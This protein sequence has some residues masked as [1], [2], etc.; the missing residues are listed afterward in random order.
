VQAGAPLVWKVKIRE[1]GKFLVGVKSTTGI[2]QRKTVVIEPPND[3]AGRFN[4]EFAGD[5][6]PGKQFTITAKV[7]EPLPGQ[8]LTATLPQG[9]Q[10]ANGDL[11]QSVAPGKE[12][13][14]SW[15]V[16]VV[17]SGRLPVRIASSTGLARTKTISLTESNKTLFGN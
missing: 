4:F 9:L 17:E 7:T 15:Q 1:A 13:I 5:I 12:S 3:L 11:T 10:L 14:V 16:R 6:R 2:T 8:T